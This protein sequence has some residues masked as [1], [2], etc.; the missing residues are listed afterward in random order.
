VRFGLGSVVSAV[1][2]LRF[3]A[4]AEFTDEDLVLYFSSFVVWKV[5]GE[6]RT[7]ESD[8]SILLAVATDILRCGL[9]QFRRLWRLARAG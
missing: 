1:L 9:G 7:T 4:S 5:S 6:R 8:G 2:K 3:E